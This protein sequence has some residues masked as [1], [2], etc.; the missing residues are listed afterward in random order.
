[1]LII[2]VLYLVV[3]IYLKFDFSYLGFWLLKYLLIRSKQTLVCSFIVKFDVSIMIESSEGF[4]GEATRYN[5]LT[6]KPY[7]I[8]TWHHTYTFKDEIYD[9]IQDII[10]IFND[11]EDLEVVFVGETD[12][13]FDVHF[14][15]YGIGT[16]CIE[17][18]D[19]DKLKIKERKVQ[20]A[21]LRLGIDKPIKTRLLLA[22]Y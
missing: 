7:Q 4:R 1:M 12:K 13:D 5:E 6:G 18:L 22:E 14:V 9:D 15:G 11:I 17:E 3:G 21:F 10:N 19:L 16:D 8:E 20:E 2:A